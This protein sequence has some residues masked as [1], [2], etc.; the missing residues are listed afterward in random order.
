MRCFFLQFCY[1]ERRQRQVVRI[2][3]DEL[4][5]KLFIYED[6]AIY[7]REEFPKHANIS[8]VTREALREAVYDC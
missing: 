6:V 7:T 1:F 8:V 5:T 2:G 3:T 4:E